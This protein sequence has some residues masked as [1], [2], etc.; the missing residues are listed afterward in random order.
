M[1]E[2]TSHAESLWGHEQRSNIIKGECF[3]LFVGY[4]EMNEG[5]KQKFLQKFSQQ[6]DKG[7]T[8]VMA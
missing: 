4:T 6:G 5:K 2:S 7:R 3:R 8:K 1:V